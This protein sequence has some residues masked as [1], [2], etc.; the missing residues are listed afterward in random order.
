MS[1]KGSGGGKNGLDLQNREKIQK[2]R[3]GDPN[4]QQGKK[5]IRGEETPLI[6]NVIFELDLG[7]EPKN[8]GRGTKNLGML[9]KGSDVPLGG[10]WGLF[11]V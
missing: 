10:G 1:W 3:L 8:P 11:N 5:R 4:Q 7:N 6:K 2:S 9:P